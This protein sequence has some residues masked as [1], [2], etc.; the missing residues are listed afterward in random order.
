MKPSDIMQ[1]REMGLWRAA[2]IV[3]A[4]LLLTF[5]IAFSSGLGKK[6]AN[7]VGWSE[8]ASTKTAREMTLDEWFGEHNGE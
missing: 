1:L 2:G 8:E 6:V 3:A 5:L 4:I 7:A